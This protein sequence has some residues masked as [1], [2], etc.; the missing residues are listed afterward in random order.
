VASPAKLIAERRPSS[1]QNNARGRWIVP[2]AVFVGGEASYIYPAG[3]NRLPFWRLLAGQ[4]C[5]G[6]RHGQWRHSIAAD[7]SDA[8][9]G[10]GISPSYSR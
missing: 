2:A 9:S 8:I 4:R 3:G 6:G 5:T 10:L 1:L 7:L